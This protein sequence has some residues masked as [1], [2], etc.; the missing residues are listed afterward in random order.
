[1]SEEELEISSEKEKERKRRLLGAG[2]AVVTSASVLVGGL[3]SSPAALTEEQDLNP[4]VL[5]SDDADPGSDDD[6]EVEEELEEEASEEEVRPGARARLRQKILELPLA[7]RLLVIL[8]LWCLGWLILGLAKLLWGLILS[9]VAAKALS[10]LL[11][12]A[13]L[14]AAFLLAGKTIFPDLPLKKI[15]NRRSLL[16][17]VIG[18]LLLG[19]ADCVLPFFW[20]GYS[21]VEAA[22]RGVGT[23]LVFGTVT[24]SFALREQKRRRAAAAE[25]AE[26]AEALEEAGEPEPPGPLSREE[27][28]ALADTVSR[29]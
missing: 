26:A 20:D 15:L 3:F 4:V 7:V 14:V 19:A 1:M 27:I 22:L 6:T 9:P 12:G 16:G 29:R 23:L 8:P 28:L 25:E 17:L 18:A 21:R 10:W 11:L 2:V 13:A 24:L 5:Y